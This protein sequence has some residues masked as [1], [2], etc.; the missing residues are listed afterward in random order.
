MAE[1]RLLWRRI[2]PRLLVWRQDSEASD[3]PKPPTPL[4]VTQ[5][6]GTW[7]LVAFILSPFVQFGTA[8]EKWLLRQ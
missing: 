4:R 7:V 6:S 5:S 3:R 8:M 2:S 1:P